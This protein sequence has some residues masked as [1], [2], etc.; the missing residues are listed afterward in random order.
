MC[1]LLFNQ[2]GQEDWV[3][4]R[5]QVLR[6]QEVQQV[7]DRQQEQEEVE[8]GQLQVVVE[9]VPRVE[10]LQLQPLFPDQALDLRHTAPL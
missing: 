3:Q 7:V 4:G 2:A 9:L 8:E 10:T 1:T 5:L 6:V